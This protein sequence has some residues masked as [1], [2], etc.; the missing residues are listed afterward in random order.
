MV[1]LEHVLVKTAGRALHGFAPV[2]GSQTAALTPPGA[3][4]AP[5]PARIPE[6][7]VI[8]SHVPYPAVVG[9]HLQYKPPSTGLVHLS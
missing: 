9:V 1:R 4:T 5:A 3:Q 2:S 7:A 6:Q 8:S